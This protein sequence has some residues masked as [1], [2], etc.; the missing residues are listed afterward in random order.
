MD[1]GP[2]V[3][4]E[5]EMGEV[6]YELDIRDV[7]EVGDLTISVLV[8]PDGTEYSTNDWQITQPKNL[9]EAPD[10][11]WIPLLG[12]EVYEVAEEDKEENQDEVTLRNFFE[13]EAEQKRDASEQL[14]SE[15]GTRDRSRG[16][17]DTEL[18][19]VD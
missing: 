7:G 16:L 6:L 4:D 5:N 12:V 8:E 13:E 10:Y 2:R 1:Q 17:S 3:L 18:E 19:S 14:A 15:T 9:D 11:I